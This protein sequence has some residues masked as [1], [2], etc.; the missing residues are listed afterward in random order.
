MYLLGRVLRFGVLGAAMAGTA[1][2]LSGAF[3][4]VLGWPI[5]SV[6][7]WSGWLF[8][9]TILVM[10]GGHRRRDVTLLAVIIALSLYAGEPDT[11]L[12]VVAAL[13]VFVVVMLVFFAP[14]QREVGV[15]RAQPAGPGPCLAGWS[16]AGRAIVATG[17]GVDLRLYPRHRAS[18]GLS[19]LPDP[20]S[21]VPD[22]RRIV[23][24]SPH[25]V[26]QPRSHLRTARCLH[27]RHSRGPG[28]DGGGPA[29]HATGGDRICGGIRDVGRHGVPVTSRILPEQSAG[30]GEIRWV[31]AIQM[32]LFVVAVLAGAGV[33][34]VA[35]SKGSQGVRRWLGA[36]FAAAALLLLLLWLFGR[37]HL[38]PTE[39]HIR[40]K[41]FIWPA[42]EVVTGLVIFG[43]L[44]LLTLTRIRERVQRMPSWLHDPGRFAAV[45]LLVSSTGFLIALG[46][47]WWS[48]S[49]SYLVPNSREMALQKAVGT[50]IVG[51]GTL[52]CWSS[53]KKSQTIGIQPEVN[54]VYGVHE[55]DSYDPLTPEDLYTSWDL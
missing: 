55:F 23:A 9:F 45:L 22:V 14:K 27:R 41:S 43:L 49:S 52:S 5:A 37:G 48:S 36:S 3:M 20:A 51:F 38:P 2:E 33:H 28:T 32:L 42:A 24:G 12:V 40:A 4:A 19:R 11:L 50:S 39:T 46:A 16:R 18:Q 17:C 54:I 1:F 30:P 47:P 34:V 29:P 53:S 35:R 31:R 6:I 8:A 25:H 21:G 26:Q 15:H 7:S 13:I 10:R 44:M